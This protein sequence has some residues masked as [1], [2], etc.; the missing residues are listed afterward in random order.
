MPV[1]INGTTGVTTPGLASA[2]MPTSGGD[3]V[4]ESGSNSDGAWTRW[5]DGTQICQHRDT[6]TLRVTDSTAGS[7]Y[8]LTA[9]T[10]PFPVSFISIPTV[11]EGGHYS[12]SSG[13]V[14]WSY[15]RNLSTTTVS[16]GLYSHSSN[17]QGFVGYTATGRWK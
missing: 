13:S 17:G 1:D 4:V 10:M 2:A 12:G 9:A 7:V 5:A 11:A 16:I 6:N 8:I 14:V 15:H 3:P